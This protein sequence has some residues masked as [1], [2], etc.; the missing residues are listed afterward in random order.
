MN[1]KYNLNYV[2][3]IL[4]SSVNSRSPEA[5]VRLRQVFILACGCFILFS[6]CYRSRKSWFDAIA[7]NK[8]ISVLR[9]L[10]FFEVLASLLLL[11]FSISL[12]SPLALHELTSYGAGNGSWLYGWGRPL[13]GIFI[14]GMGTMGDMHPLPRLACLLGV[15][16]GMVGDAL[17][18]Y[19]IQDYIQQTNQLGAPLEGQY[20]MIALVIYYYRDL[21]S[22]G[23]CVWIMLLNCLFICTVGICNPPFFQY[24]VIAGGDFDRCEVMRRERASEKA[25]QA[26]KERSHQDRQVQRSKGFEVDSP[27]CTLADYIPDNNFSV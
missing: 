7:A 12:G 27:Q 11:Y 8:M 6:P 5:V 10:I 19:Q 26:W 24:Q 25:Y 16:M 23:L 22:F 3:E 20:S 18:A 15:F 2:T 13:T 14:V 1:I 9:I 21:V 17:S 4:I